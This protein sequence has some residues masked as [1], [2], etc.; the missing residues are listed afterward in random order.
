MIIHRIVP[1]IV[2]NYQSYTTVTTKVIAIPIEMPIVPI[3]Y[4]K[5]Y[6]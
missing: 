3:N 6:I 4:G 5:N 1:I 2:V